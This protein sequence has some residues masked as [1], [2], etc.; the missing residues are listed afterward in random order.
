MVSR[1]CLD[2]LRAR[3]S[4]REDLGEVESRYPAPE[5]RSGPEQEAVLAD[6]V[7]GA[8]SVVLDM[9]SPVERVAFVLHDV[10]DVGFDEIGRTIERSPVAA[11]K[12]ASRARMRVRGAAG[13]SPERDVEEQRRVVDAFLSA[14]R[15]GDLE[16]LITLLAP[17]VVF[18]SDPTAAA[19]AD[20]PALV[21]G[22]SSVAAAFSGGGHAARSALV[23]GEVFVLVRPSGRLIVILEIVVFDGKIVA[24]D[25]VADPDRLAHVEA[26]GFDQ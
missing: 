21:D 1:V 17:D 7:G 26:A 24:I 4:R 8:L 3:A 15:Q 13:A 23:D 25:A 2:M 16:G 9:L 12:L 6:A 14:A 11:R 10:F 22:A 19:L 18:R 5:E 20:G